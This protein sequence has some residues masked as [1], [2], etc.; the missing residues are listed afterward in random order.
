MPELIL[1]APSD[2]QE[3]Y[4]LLNAA[5]QHPGPAAVRYPVA[6]GQGHPQSRRS[7]FGRG[8]GRQVLSGQQVALLNFGVLL[9]EAQAI[10]QRRVL[11]CVICAGLNPWI[12]P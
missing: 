11:L 2:E 3:C 7:P 8:V 10:A 9:P 12:P 1:A 4:Q 5:Y 6:M